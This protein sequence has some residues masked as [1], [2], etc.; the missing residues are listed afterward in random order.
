MKRESPQRLLVVFERLGFFV[1]VK[2]SIP[3]GTTPK[4]DQY[5]ESK[6]L[7][8]DRFGCS[9]APH[10]AKVSIYGVAFDLPVELGLLNEWQSDF[11]RHARYHKQHSSCCILSDVSKS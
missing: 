5:F 4:K 10:H 9:D 7:E 6:L 2:M 8:L 1:G 11:V 3:K